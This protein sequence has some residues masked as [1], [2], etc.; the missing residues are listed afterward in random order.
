[1]SDKGVVEQVFEQGG[2]FSVGHT[3]A[4]DAAA[5]DIEDDIEVEIRVFGRSHELGDYPTTRLGWRLR[6]ATRA[7]GGRDGGAG[8]GVRG[9]RHFRPGCDTWCGSS[10]DRRPRPAGW[11]GS[12]RGQIDEP[13]RSQ[14]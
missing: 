1:M 7:S 5:E 6:P 14:K 2:V 3:P 10:N 4:G 11:H 9:L 12:P 13:G 8:R